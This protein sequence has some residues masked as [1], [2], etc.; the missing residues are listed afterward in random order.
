MRDHGECQSRIKSRSTRIPTQACTS[1]STC[2]CNKINQ[3][4]I[5]LVALDADAIASLGDREIDGRNAFLASSLSR[6][7]GFI[8]EQR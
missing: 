6:V 2:V 5:A 1:T 3:R 4:D 8:Q 7:T